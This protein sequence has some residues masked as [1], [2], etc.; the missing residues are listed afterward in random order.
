LTRDLNGKVD[1]DDSP[2]IA[3]RTL[4]CV[5]VMWLFLGRASFGE[6]QAPT[7]GDDSAALAEKLNPGDS[8]VAGAALSRLPR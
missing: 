5:T 6:E 7:A 3:R 8:R 2:R 1:H 4:L